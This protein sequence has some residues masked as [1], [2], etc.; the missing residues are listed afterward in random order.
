MTLTTYIRVQ[1]IEPDGQQPWVTALIGQNLMDAALAA[2]I[3]GITG[4]C[5][6]AI[7]CATCLCD[8]APSALSG[9]PDQHPDELE[10]LSYVD[11]ASTNSRLAC[12]LIASPELDGLILQVVE[13]TN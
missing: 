2:G 3:A 5:G 9:L 7:N 8:L 4:Q 12:Q 1:F 10:L 6:G 13:S 11:E